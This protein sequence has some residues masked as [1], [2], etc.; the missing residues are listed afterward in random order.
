MKRYSIALIPG[1]GIGQEV[2]ASARKVLEA[3]QTNS[4]EFGLDFEVYPAGQEEF[5]A[6]GNAL[7][8]ETLA[9]IRKADAALIGA[10]NASPSPAPSPV[11]QLRKELGL[12]ADV[13]PVKAWPGIWSIKPDIDIICIRENTEGFLADRNLYMGNGEFMP[14]EDVVMSVRVLT[15]HGS[16]RIAKYAFELARKQNRKKIT[17]VHKGNVL[18]RGCGFFLEI[19]KETAKKYPEIVLTDEYVDNVANNLILRPESYDVL[20]ATNLFGDII[21]DEA[22]A[23]VSNI[24][25]SVNVGEGCAVFSPINHDGKN[26]EAGRNTASPLVHIT[27][28]GMLLEH[29]GEAE[30]GRKIYQAVKDV[31]KEGL[32][33]PRDLGGNSSTTEITSAVCSRISARGDRQWE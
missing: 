10:L 2:I 12:Y 17:V 19:V 25:P 26:S 11:G 6:T 14:T 1:D 13:R 8:Q 29:L 5:Q 24:V 9:G 16:E 3:V 33:K 21:S 22:A 7:P 28:A 18:R 32:V 31:L 20:L 27:C 30:A 4:G 15:R 23:L